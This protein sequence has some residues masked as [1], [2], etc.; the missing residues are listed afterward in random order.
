MEQYLLLTVFILLGYLCGSIPF[1]YLISKIK[2]VDIRK[3]GSGNIGA[4]NISRV[5]GL[6]YALMV[7]ILDV[8]KALIPIYIASQYITNEWHLIFII[9]SPV[10]GHVFSFWLD[11]KGGKAVS[12]IF[13]SIIYILGWKYSII[14]LVFWAVIL[15]TIKIMSLTNLLIILLTP[16]L[17]WMG[18]DHST[19]YLVLGIFYVI[20]VFWAHRGNIKRLLKGTE[21]RIIK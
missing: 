3:Q 12:T 20:I 17:F 21:K 15:K 10:L 11:F 7:G 16:I 14:I 2:K 5:F 9:I 1:G 6:K 4:T 19:A 13:G 8:S 18:K